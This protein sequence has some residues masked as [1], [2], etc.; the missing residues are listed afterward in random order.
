MPPARPIP[1]R[2]GPP[3]PP[4]ERGPP[5]R[6]GPPGEQGC[7]GMQGRIGEQG[8]PGRQGI[9]GPP[10]RQ[11]IPGVVANDFTFYSVFVRDLGVVPQVFT[12]V[13][14][15]SST[16]NKYLNSVTIQQIDNTVVVVLASTGVINKAFVLNGILGSYGTD[17]IILP[18]NADGSVFQI[19]VRWN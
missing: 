19:N 18:G 8:P 16:D 13:T 12:P 17:T 6:E 1:G 3:G 11:G 15:Y 9:P 7:M 2:E 4:G 14:M 10:G 5:G